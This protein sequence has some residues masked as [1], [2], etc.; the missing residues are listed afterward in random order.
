M[1]TK[2]GITY[3]ENSDLT[4]GAY[5]GTIE[6][7][8][9]KSKINI[10]Y[11]PTGVDLYVKAY[12]IEDGNRI[13]SPI[14]HY[15]LTNWFYIKNEYAGQNTLTISVT[16]HTGNYRYIYSFDKEHWTEVSVSSTYTITMEEGEKV[17]FRGGLSYRDSYGY[18]SM[19]CSQ[20]YSIGGDVSTVKG[21]S[22]GPTALARNGIGGLFAN[23]T[24]LVDASNLDFS[25]IDTIDDYGMAGTF[26][27]CTNLV[28]VPDMSSIKYVYIDGMSGTF[29]GT[30]INSIDLSGVTTVGFYS[31]RN[32]FQNSKISSIS[33]GGN[34]TT[35]G[36]DSTNNGTSCFLECFRGCTNLVR[37]IDLSK[38]TSING[39]GSRQFRQ[40]YQGCT[41]LEEATFP[42]RVTT[43]GTSTSASCYNWLRQAGTSVSG[44]KTVNCPT[45]V[46]VPTGSESG[47]P[48]G[49]T[50]VDY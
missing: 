3:S 29:Y 26:Q 17:Y 7:N 38:I 10:P 9:E 39:N 12:C 30:K 16:G 37:G 44:T 49:W 13:E 46:N 41:H 28:G 21:G 34:L 20:N 11:Y 22:S 19:T 2:T 6:E 8:G 25:G 32:C 40:M 42:K 33:M 14:H 1:I 43:L 18:N 45:G 35:I 31:F 47:V 24:T 48:T 36:F 15:M 50:K 4:P 27:G 5:S 23:S